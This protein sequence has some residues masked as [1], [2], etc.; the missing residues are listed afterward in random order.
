M[1]LEQ[2]AADF[3]QDVLAR[4]ESEDDENFREDAFTDL[5]IEYL[6]ENGEL[7]DAQ[8]CSQRGHGWKVSGYGLSMDEE[9]LDLLISHYA[10]S[11][12]PESM[13]K[14]EV[15]RSMKR[16]V[17]FFGQSISAD[18]Y[19][20]LPESSPVFD[21][22]L[23]IHELAKDKSLERVRLFLLTD[24]LTKMNVLED[25][26]GIALNGVK[27]PISA[28]VWDI[29]RLYRSWS[30]GR[31]R[32]SIKVDF[33]DLFQ[34]ALP[35]LAMPDDEAVEYN[36]FLALFPGSMLYRIYDIY[37]PRLLERNVRSFLQ[38]KGNVNQAIRR[39]IRE[40]PRM[41][42]AYNNGISATAEEVQ[43]VQIPG[44]GFGIAAIS[45]FQIVNGGQTTASIYHAVN[46]DRAAIDGL[47]VQ[48]KL[49]VLKDPERMDDIV[50]KISESANTQNKVQMADFSA[51]QPF[52][53][54]LEEL[55]RTVWAPSAT[56][57]EKQTRWFY[58]RARGQYADARARAGTP[59]KRK[60]Y[61]IQHPPQQKFTKIDLAKYEHSWQQLPQYVSEGAQKNFARFMSRLKDSPT[62]P[63]QQFF[64][65]LIAKAI[66]FKQT[67]KLVSAQKFGGYRANIVT[68]AI[69]WLCVEAAKREKQ[70]DLQRIWQSQHLSPELEQAII[71]VSHHVFESITHPT[72]NANVTEWC[73][74]EA[75]WKTIREL[76]V[77]LPETFYEQLVLVESQQGEKR[78]KT[79]G[80]RKM[81]EEESEALERLRRVDKTMWYVIL[82]KNGMEHFLTVDQE[83]LA[84]CLMSRKPRVD[85]IGVATEII[86]ECKRRGLN[87]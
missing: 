64:E 38:A 82:Q 25:V 84:E 14:T 76:E 4:A 81:T 30:S 59:A 28:Q 67:E 1:E 9:C 17:S 55:S 32:E 56:G 7:D 66:L 48:M 8:V 73:K 26:E 87:L 43:I 15:Q 63:G 6:C 5:M 80:K 31:R 35:C 10:G 51:N 49:T 65:E 50:P 57:T 42:L 72:G 33:L 34:E 29:E 3:H 41:F 85:D 21:L 45:D 83:K 19:Q 46:R 23:R 12:P 62:D 40:T 20:S 13:T 27:I 2:F 71:T 79:N 11:V 58:E 69:A 77:A 37:G 16:L 52:H 78:A 68:Y 54:T 47:Y 61:E 60:E 75:C 74:R 39:T 24:C 18:F 44:G 86:E 53:R 22:A 36:T 70:I